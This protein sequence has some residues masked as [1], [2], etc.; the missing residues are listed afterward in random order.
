MMSVAYNH[1][2]RPKLCVLNRELKGKPLDVVIQDWADGNPADRRRQC[3]TR[4]AAAQ[5]VAQQVSSS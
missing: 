1:C 2:Q 4:V 5:A 3:R